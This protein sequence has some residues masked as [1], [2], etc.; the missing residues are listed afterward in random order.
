MT[1]RAFDSPSLAQGRPRARTVDAVVTSA[2]RMAWVEA[3]C[4]TTVASWNS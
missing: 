1:G 4:A 2:A 3:A